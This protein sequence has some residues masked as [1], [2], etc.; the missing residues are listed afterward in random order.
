LIQTKPFGG[1]I[2]LKFETN[3]RFG[4]FLIEE[5]R[6]NDQSNFSTKHWGWFV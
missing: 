4:C 1:D 3:S 2:F 6:R 5:I